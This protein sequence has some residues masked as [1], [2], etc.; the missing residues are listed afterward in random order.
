MSKPCGQDDTKPCVTRVKA[1]TSS[2]AAAH[3]VAARPG[4]ELT[5]S[6]GVGAPA[7]IAA[8]REALVEATPEG[9]PSS[10][11]AAIVVHAWR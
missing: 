5:N 6:G 3:H 1:P 10:S 8:R 4:K 7:P 2:H 9:A 11:R